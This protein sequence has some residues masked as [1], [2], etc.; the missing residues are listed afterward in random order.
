MKGPDL[1]CS[2][3][4]HCLLSKQAVY[5]NSSGVY[6]CVSVFN[7]VLVGFC[8]YVMCFTFGYTV[9]CIISQELCLYTFILLGR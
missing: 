1:K 9:T 7:M 3:S 6:V 8:L 5:D 4:K 2:G